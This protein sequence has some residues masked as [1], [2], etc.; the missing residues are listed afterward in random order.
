[1]NPCKTF[2]CRK[3]SEAQKRQ[4]VWSIDG[5]PYCNVC[6]LNWL[7]KNEV[8]NQKIVRLYNDDALYDDCRR[9]RRPHPPKPS[10]AALPA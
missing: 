7:D 3:R 4:A 10:Q 1:M 2:E 5:R 8:G 6:F 9:R